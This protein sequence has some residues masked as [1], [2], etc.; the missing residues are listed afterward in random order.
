MFISCSLNPKTIHE[1]PEVGQ[2]IIDIIKKV[3]C[4][5]CTN[6]CHNYGDKCKYGF[7]RYPLKETIVV[8]K[9]EFTDEPQSDNEKQKE[10]KMNHSKL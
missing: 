6:P 8:D 4:H 1:D 10:S 9:K 2:R 5:N 7:P 3:N